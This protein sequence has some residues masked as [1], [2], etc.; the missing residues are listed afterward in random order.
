VNAAANVGEQ[1][2]R[3][4]FITNF[5]SHYRVPLFELLGQR[6]NY[7]FVFFSEG[8]EGYW[9]EHL[10][11]SHVDATVETVRGR[12]LGGGLRY[13]PGLDRI[14]ARDDYDVVVKCMNGKIE[15]VSAFVAARLRR[16]PFVLWSG[17]WEHPRTPLHALTAPM[18]DI[19]YRGSDAIVCYGTHVA[20]YVVRRGAQRESVFVA[21]N[22]VDNEFY[23]QPVSALQRREMRARW[24]LEDRQVVLSV[25]RL[26]EQKGL[27]HLVRA[28]GGL[29]DPRPAVVVVG[30][31]DGGPELTRLAAENGVDLVLLGGVLPEALPPIY[32]SA[33]V[34]VLASV[35]TP[36]ITETW[37]LTLNEAMCQGVPVIATDA[38]GAVAGGL[39]VNGVTGLVVD[40][41]DSTGLSL[42][43]SR[44]LGDLG[45]AFELGA[46]GKRRVERTT[47]AGMAEAFDQAVMSAWRRR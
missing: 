22:A 1:R 13:N 27:D 43:L 26:T 33:D 17:M 40:S 20:D 9:Q 44:V 23:S 41:G 37:G 2:P 10:G 45:F 8:A 19:V 5:A 3:V 39:V 7:R 14:L 35:R 31:G 24:G 38:V 28:V 42:A 36:Q 11:V 34:C 25:S 4:L 21:E 47:I 46:A 15:L 16:K 12:E 30:T 6:G 29:P 18:A 32:A